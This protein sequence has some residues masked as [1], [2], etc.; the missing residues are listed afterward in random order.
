MNLKDKVE[1]YFR[2]FSE[3]NIENLSDLF[4]NEII[5]KDWEILAI[6]KKEVI[7]ANK[8]IFSSVQS[9]CVNLK[10]FYQQDNVTTCLIEIEINNEEIIKVIDIIKFNEEFKIKEISAYKQ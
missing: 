2:L 4:S 9:I 10:E 8:K 1:T 7:S 3:K 5:L 6:G